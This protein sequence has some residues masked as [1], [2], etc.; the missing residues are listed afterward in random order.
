LHQV[1]AIVLTIFVGIIVIPAAVGAGLVWL[2][3]SWEISEDDQL[4]S[5]KP[6]ARWMERVLRRHFEAWL[7]EKPRQLTYRR[8]RRGRF[9]RIRRG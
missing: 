7:A 6:N 5:R 9:R 1:T 8:D 4:Y 3:G 2:A